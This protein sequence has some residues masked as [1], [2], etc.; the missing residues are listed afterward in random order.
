MSATSSA[1]E[2]RVDRLV[3]D[4]IARRLAA[5]A[6][7]ILPIGA[8][9]KEHGLHM[10]MGTDRIQ[11]EWLSDRLALALMKA[12]HDALIWP[13]LSYGYYPAFT[14]YAGSVTLSRPAFRM[15][16]GEIAAGLVQQ[17]ACRV[18]VLDTGIST[19]APVAEAL[20]GLAAARHLR[21]HAGPRYT[22][23]ARR[24]ARQRFGSHADELETSR[25]LV[26]EPELLDMS[27]AEASPEPV[28]G[29]RPGP[30]TPSDASSP[31][32]SP[33]G[34][35]GDPSLATQAKG[36]ALLAAMLEDLLEAA[37]A[38]LAGSEATVP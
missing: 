14:A 23:A 10:P 37:Q 4:E 2:H 1:C 12:G 20:Q 5:G 36:V 21:I 16:V 26:I 38:A 24:L 6:A 17:G 25:M 27:R 35:Y 18:L 28:G 3:W 30:L 31:N 9:A 29:P 22:E 32:Y 13:A 15:V 34:S 7:A 8:G 33:S 19:I 11:A